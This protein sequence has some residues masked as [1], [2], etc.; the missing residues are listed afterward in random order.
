MGL[1]K[2]DAQACDLHV[3]R[4]AR[5]TIKA[6]TPVICFEIEHSGT[7]LHNETVEDYAKFVEE[8]G[9]QGEAVYH[10]PSSEDWVIRP[11]EAK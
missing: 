8:I 7:H 6:Q 1:I 9:Y 5:E 10:G 2:I 11:K 3:M 4:G